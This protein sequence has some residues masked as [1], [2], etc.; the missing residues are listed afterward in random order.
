MINKKYFYQNK[1]IL[2]FFWFVLFNCFTYIKN[3]KQP[4]VLD[5]RQVL[6]LPFPSTS[7]P[8]WDN[9]P[10]IFATGKKKIL[11]VK[12]YREF[13]QKSSKKCVF[14]LPFWYICAKKAFFETYCNPSA[15]E[16]LYER[17]KFVICII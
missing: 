17:Y 16:F 6:Y 10:N 4:I 9:C 11:Q 8:Y 15:N 1:S 14:H 12:L 2:P 5:Q 13:Q 3:S 7:D